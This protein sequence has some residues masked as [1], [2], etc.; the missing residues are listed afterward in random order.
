MGAGNALGGRGEH[1]EGRR[2]MGSNHNGKDDV[3]CYQANAWKLHIES[4]C[5]VPEKTTRMNDGGQMSGR[6]G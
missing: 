2:D 5:W 1:D 3:C 4:C 6:D